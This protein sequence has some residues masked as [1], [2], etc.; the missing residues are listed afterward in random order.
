MC[1]IFERDTRSLNLV[2]TAVLVS[3]TADELHRAGIQHG[4]MQ[5]FIT[6]DPHGKIAHSNFP[7][8]NFY[9][10]WNALCVALLRLK[11]ILIANMAS[12]SSELLVGPIFSE[13]CLPPHSKCMR[14]CIASIGFVSDICRTGCHISLAMIILLFLLLQSSHGGWTLYL[15]VDLASY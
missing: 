4:H 1:K 7:A 13:Y 11:N 3:S 6:Y 10:F 9:R 8:F 12:D 15:V 2:M 14:T 5:V